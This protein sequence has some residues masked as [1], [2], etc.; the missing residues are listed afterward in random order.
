MA[1]ITKDGKLTNTEADNK[2]VEE[3]LKGK[4]LVPIRDPETNEV[5]TYLPFIVTSDS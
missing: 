2:I 1:I 5:Y 3:F 4:P